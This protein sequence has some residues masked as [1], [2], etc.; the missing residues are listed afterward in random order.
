MLILTRRKGQ[1]VLVGNTRITL[2]KIEWNRVRLC[3][4]GSEII[5]RKLKSAVIKG[6][7]RMQR[8]EVEKSEIKLGIH[9][10]ESMNIVRMEA[11]GKGNENVL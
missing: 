10:P 11:V 5:I 3:V 2:N 7:I 6:G 1:S 8:C 9:A 4:N